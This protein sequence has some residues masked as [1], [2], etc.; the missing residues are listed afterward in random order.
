MTVQR[1]QPHHRQTSAPSELNRIGQWIAANATPPGGKPAVLTPDQAAGVREDCQ[2]FG[3]TCEDFAHAY[4]Q[5]AGDRGYVTIGAARGKARVIAKARRGGGSDTQDDDTR[6]AAYRA[7][8]R[9]FRELQAAQGLRPADIAEREAVQLE[10][11]AL[12][13]RRP[14]EGDPQEWG[15]QLACGHVVA[16]IPHLDGAWRWCGECR[17]EGQ[18]PQWGD[19]ERG[20]HYDETLGARLAALVPGAKGVG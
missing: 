5:I 18:P 4:L 7:S 16:R 1:P 17:D 3:V 2:R 15:Q 14:P 20:R 9:H 8:A 6:A 10:L 11:D 13:Y 19:M 12:G